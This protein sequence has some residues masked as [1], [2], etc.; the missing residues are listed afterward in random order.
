MGLVVIISPSFGVVILT[1]PNPLT[2][3][4]CVSLGSIVVFGTR[5]IGLAKKFGTEVLLLGVGVGLALLELVKLFKLSIRSN[6][7]EGILKTATTNSIIGFLSYSRSIFFFL[8][9]LE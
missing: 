6:N 8:A 1:G 9:V 2:H 5:L 4:A 7:I 3:G